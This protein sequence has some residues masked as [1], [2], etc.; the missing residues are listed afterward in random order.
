MLILG[1]D[2]SSSIGSVALRN[3]QGIRGLLTVSVD[4]THS[5]GLMPA[6]D[7]LLERTHKRVDD[8]TAIACVKGPGSY[9]GLRIGIATA[10]GLAFGRQL[11]GFAFSSLEVL[12]WSLPHCR[13]HL[14]PIIAAR[15]GWMYAQVFSWD[16]KQPDPVTQELYVQPEELISHITEPTVFFGPGLSP[17]IQ[18]LQGMLRDDCI[19]IPSTYDL[20]R[21]DCL[22][23]LAFQTLENGNAL[24]PH[25]MQ[26]HYLGAS[27][28][29]INWKRLHQK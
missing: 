17:F 27:Q 28:A 12:A 19:L 21:A 4:L 25:E 24:R 5:E 26:P 6:I 15:K 2:T 18:P 9:T 1:I 14:C 16:Q 8:L 22:T 29:E 23:Q 7:R 11:P 3:Q 20:P 10:Q 13:Y